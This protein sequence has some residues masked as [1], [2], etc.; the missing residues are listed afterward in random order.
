MRPSWRCLAALQAVFLAAA[1]GCGDEDGGGC[2]PAPEKKQEEQAPGPSAAGRASGGAGPAPELK[3]T[4]GKRSVPDAYR[5]PGARD[6]DNEREDRALKKPSVAKSSASKEGDAPAAMPLTPPPVKVLR[7]RVDGV[8]DRVETHCRMMASSPDGDC[9]GSKNYL[10]IKTRCCPDGLVE[11][12]RPVTD[13]VI[14]VGRG[15]APNP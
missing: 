1:L 2:G 3:T 8:A 11:R 4:Q 9:A 13:G 10:E 7:R 6:A 14:I 15:C 5:R 12:C